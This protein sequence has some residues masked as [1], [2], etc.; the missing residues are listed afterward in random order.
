MKWNEMTTV[1]RVIYVVG[2]ISGF[3]YLVLSA[4]DLFGLLPI[5]K[6]ILFP[7]FSVFWLNLGM[8]QKVKKNAIWYYIL[9]AVYVVIALLYIFA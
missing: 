3:S 6:G 2:L 4:L 5:S 8:I 1:Q 9:A 7:L